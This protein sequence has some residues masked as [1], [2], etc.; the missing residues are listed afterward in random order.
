MT[1]GSSGIETDTPPPKASPAFRYLETGEDWQLD[2]TNMPGGP[3]SIY[4]LVLGNTLQG[5]YIK[6]K[7]R[8]SS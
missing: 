4:L 2:L 7:N 6:Q 1:V 8:R 5:V 3:N